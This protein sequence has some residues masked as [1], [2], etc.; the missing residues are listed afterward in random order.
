MKICFL[1]KTNLG[2][3][4]VGWILLAVFTF[5][6]FWLLIALGERGGATFFSNLKLTIPGLSI[7]FFGTASFAVGIISI[8]KKKERSSLV[9]LSAILGFMILLFFL[10]EIL[11]PH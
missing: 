8:I 9:F 4:S 3:W 7:V 2:K 10:A 5:A 11:F 1:P 6:I